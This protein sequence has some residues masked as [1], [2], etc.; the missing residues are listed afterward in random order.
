MPSF[1]NKSLI[2]LKKA[3]LSIWQAVIV[4]IITGTAGVLGALITNP[5]RATDKPPTAAAETRG[6]RCA[7][8]DDL[9]LIELYLRNFKQA[10]ADLNHELL[11]ALSRRDIGAKNA[12]LASVQAQFIPNYEIWYEDLSGKISVLIDK[13]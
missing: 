5:N 3:R 12:A 7:T 11:R 8:K 1:T 10:T 4:A 2:E 6:I 13:C 9:Q